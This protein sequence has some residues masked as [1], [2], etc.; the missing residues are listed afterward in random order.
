MIR[1][2]ALCVCLLAAATPVAQEMPRNVVLFIG[3]GYGPAYAELARAVSGAPLAMDAILVGAAQTAPVDSRV[4]DS[5]AGATAYSCGLTTHN[6]YIAMGPAGRPCRTFLEA[7]GRQGRAVGVVTTTRVTHA[8]PAAFAAHHV[9]R[10]AE[11]DIAAQMAGAGLDV[12]FGGGAAFFRP[13][14]AGGRRSDERD[15]LHELSAAGY[16]VV[17]DPDCFD[18]IDALPAAAL[19]AGDH[20]AYEIDRD[21]TSEPSLAAMT[22][23]AIGLLHADGRPFV[24]VVEGGRID[25]AGHGNAPAE[26]AADVLAYDAAVGA[27]LEWARADGRTLV[28]GV[29]DHETGGL[30]LG[31]DDVYD[32]HPAALRSVTQSAD[33]MAERIRAGEDAAVVLRA[34]A[35]ID[36]VGADELAALSGRDPRAAL[37]RVVSARAGIAWT[38]GGHTAVEVPVYA[39]GPGAGRFAGSRPAA[40]VGR[41]LGEA[42]GREFSD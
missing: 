29:S 7:A 14:S 26:A 27:A 40:E 21:E 10:G 23:A 37:A 18:T 36:S 28:V 22:M 15:L 5:A 32:W 30:S 2:I 33:R 16:T 39:F 9:D 20:M 42:V 35:G 13:A 8:T 11:E 17:T 41:L 31:R 25:H 38:T 19:L 3:D 6:A 4:A 12:L 24:L 34:A 1:P